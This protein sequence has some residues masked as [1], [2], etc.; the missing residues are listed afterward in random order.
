MIGQKDAGTLLN[1]HM[2]AFGVAFSKSGDW[3]N[4]GSIGSPAAPHLAT[5]VEL[6]ALSRLTHRASAGNQQGV[7]AQLE[8]DSN[9]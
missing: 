4:T 1:N 7:V 5:A 6:A 3:L 9:V 2:R 8:V